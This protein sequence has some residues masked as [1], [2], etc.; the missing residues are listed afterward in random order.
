LLR[1]YRT[2]QSLEHQVTAVQIYII[3]LKS[4]NPAFRQTTKKIGNI[5]EIF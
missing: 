5:S 4:L 2:I 3:P 1:Y